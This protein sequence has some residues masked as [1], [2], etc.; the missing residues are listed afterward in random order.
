MQIGTAARG[1]SVASPS[2][3]LCA[4]DHEGEWNAAER[5]SATVRDPVSP[6]VE[7]RGS[8][9]S[10]Q[11]I[12][13][14][15]QPPASAASAHKY[16]HNRWRALYGGE[17]PNGPLVIVHDSDER[18]IAPKEGAVAYKA[19]VDAQK[20]AEKTARRIMGPWNKEMIESGMEI[21]GFGPKGP[22]AMD[23]VHLASKYD[24]IAEGMLGPF[25]VKLCSSSQI[26]DALGMARRGEIYLA[27]EL[28]GEACSVEK[29]VFALL[30]EAS[31][32]IGTE[33]KAYLDLS[34]FLEHDIVKYLGKTKKFTNNADSIAAF[35]HRIG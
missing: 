18:P 24:S 13:A 25:T 33:D 15:L 3:R 28:L 1:D 8:G 35:A 9:P 11:R 2:G 23:K 10:R 26:D 22:S 7:P 19:T 16:I 30:H 21:F 20:R 29:V 27:R 4:A 5:K 12:G 34:Q 32:C 31:H 17:L 14:P 6:R